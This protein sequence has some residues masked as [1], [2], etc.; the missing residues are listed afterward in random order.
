MS[1]ADPSF[2]RTFAGNFI[3]MRCKFHTDG[4]RI[5]IDKL[6]ACNI[7]EDQEAVNW[8]NN[9]VFVQTIADFS[10]TIGS[11]LSV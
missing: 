10:Y 5:K 3:G 4:A 2:P 7:Y 9:Y 1:M 11:G 8:S 6:E